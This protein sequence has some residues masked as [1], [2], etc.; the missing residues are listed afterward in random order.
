[1]DTLFCPKCKKDV[2]FYTILKSNQNTARCMN[3]ETFIKNIPYKAPQFFVGKYKNIP[4]TDIDDLGYLEW[5]V[6]KMGNLNTRT[7][8]A[9][10]SRIAQLQFLAK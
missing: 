4:I 8:D 7:L 3:C 5:A 9:I 10:K 2:E 6:Q 1:M